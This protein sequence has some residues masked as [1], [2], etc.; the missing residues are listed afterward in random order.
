MNEIKVSTHNW[1]NR[2]GLHETAFLFNECGMRWVV[3]FGEGRV[4]LRGRTLK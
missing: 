4:L 3:E 1:L 2:I